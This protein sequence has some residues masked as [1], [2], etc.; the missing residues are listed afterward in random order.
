MHLEE[1]ME[2]FFEKELK[3]RCD[4][5]PYHDLYLQWQTTKNSIP[6][7]LSLI[8][9]VFPHFTLH[10]S[11]HSE[12]ILSNIKKFLPE[13]SILQLTTTDIW[14]LLFAAYFHDIGMYVSK[15]DY[16]ETI[17][18]KA[19]LEFIKDVQE[20]SNN[21]LWKY[22]NFFKIIN[23][24]LKYKAESISMESVYSL[25]YLIAGFLRNKHAER[26]KDIIKNNSFIYLPAS[27]PSRIVDL[28]AEICQ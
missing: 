17:E 23:N 28:L 20:D 5:T 19:F 10:D 14:M 21:P 24:E 15:D 22:A 26:S 3:K 27:I 1:N 9:N 2:N 7:F 16:K 8:I 6:E 4:N 13:N 25:K 18:S 11:S 12:N